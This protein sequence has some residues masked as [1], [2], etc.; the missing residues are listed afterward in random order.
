MNPGKT[1]KICSALAESTGCNA[2]KV[3]DSEAAGHRFLDSPDESRIDSGSHS[4][5][6]SFLCAGTIGPSATLGRKP[7]R[8]RGDGRG[9]AAFHFA[10]D[11]A[12]VRFN[13][14]ARNTRGNDGSSTIQTPVL[15][16]AECRR[17]GRVQ[18]LPCAGPGWARFRECVRWRNRPGCIKPAEGLR[19]CA[20]FRS[21]H[22]S[23]ADAKCAPRSFAIRTSADFQLSCIE[24]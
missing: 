9:S 13:R 18:R 8:V 16:P 21:M 12:S 2:S 7:A 11:P 20:T 4:L 15:R 19:G 1:N 3:V 5:A 22:A 23:I 17:G 14:C 10:S 24:T 6:K